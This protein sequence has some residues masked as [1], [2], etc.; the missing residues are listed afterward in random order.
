M[1]VSFHFLWREIGGLDLLLGVGPTTYP[2]SRAA[3]FDF[4]ELGGDQGSLTSRRG[5]ERRYWLFGRDVV[6]AVAVEASDKKEMDQTKDM[7]SCN[8][9]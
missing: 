4:W 6:I 1:T 7:C 9:V 5:R 3:G 2:A 8:T